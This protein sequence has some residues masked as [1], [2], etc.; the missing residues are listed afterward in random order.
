[1]VSL[2]QYVG[3]IQ[4]IRSTIIFNRQQI[5]SLLYIDALVDEDHRIL[6]SDQSISVMYAFDMR[7]SW[8]ALSTVTLCGIAITRDQFL[9]VRDQSWTNTGKKDGKELET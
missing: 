4:V 1:M 6:L 7:G 2:F 9:A 3:I 8:F 5:S